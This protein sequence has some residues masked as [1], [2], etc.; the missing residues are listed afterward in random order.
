MN[1]ENSL[2]ILDELFHRLSNA[3]IIYIP[4]NGLFSLGANF[5]EW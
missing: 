4:Y 1:Q 3:A 5:H 2:I